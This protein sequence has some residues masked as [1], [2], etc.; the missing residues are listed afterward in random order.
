MAQ[1]VRLDECEQ[2]YLQRRLEAPAQDEDAAMREALEDC[3]RRFREQLESTSPDRIKAERKSR[4]R[5]AAEVLRQ[6][7]EGLDALDAFVLLCAELGETLIAV[8]APTSGRSWKHQSLFTTYGRSLRVAREVLCLLHG[9][10]AD[11]A[12]GRWRTLHELSV[13]TRF[14]AANDEEL[15]RRYVLHR[16][17]QAHRSAAL[18]QRF[19]GRTSSTPIA[20]DVMRRL[21]EE[22]DRLVAEFGE[23]ILEDWGWAALVI[24]KKR[25]RFSDIEEFQGRDLLR[26]NYRWASEDIHGAFNPSGGTLGNDNDADGILSG[27][28]LRGLL[29]PAYWTALSLMDAAVAVLLFVPTLDRIALARVITTEAN[30]I[31]EIFHRLHTFHNKR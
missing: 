8:T 15:S 10:F 30:R 31:G 25:I 23:E 2:A 4:A 22:K 21:A 11:G 5:F 16:L 24:K 26:P 13:V 9:G 28:S 6:W 17:G 14:L 1:R 3:I 27:A 20:D 29:D 12:L 19:A 7:R 18:H